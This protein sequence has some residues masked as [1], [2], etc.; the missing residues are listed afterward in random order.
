MQ[1]M[2]PNMESILVSIFKKSFTNGTIWPKLISA[3]TMDKQELDFSCFL[4][5]WFSWQ[6][7]RSMWICMM[8]VWKGSN[9]HTLN[10]FLI[11]LLI[12]VIQVSTKNLLFIKL[13]LL[14]L[15][16]EYSQNCKVK[17]FVLEIFKGL[18]IKCYQ[19]RL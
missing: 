14:I 19:F 17:N 2:L 1:I 13:I 12:Q 4:W 18:K 3:S 6:L 11:P 16:I 8:L 10:I 5:V 7:D 15:L 9:M